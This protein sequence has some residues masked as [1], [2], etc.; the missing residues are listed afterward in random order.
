[1]RRVRRE[2]VT[3]YLTPE[4]RDLLEKDFGSVGRGVRELIKRYV[5]SLGPKEHKLRIAWTWLLRFRRPD[6]GTI[7]YREAIGVLKRHLGVDTEGAQKILGELSARGFV[8]T[9]ETGVLRVHEKG[10][11]PTPELMFLLGLQR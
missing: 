4:E 9:A 3:I 11:L 5:Y 10:V 6:T 2:R 8:S 1:M 7:P